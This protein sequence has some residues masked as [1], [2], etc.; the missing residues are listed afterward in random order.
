MTV[1]DGIERHMFVCF[2]FVLCFEILQ[3]HSSHLTCIERFFVS[4]LYKH[5]VRMTGLYSKTT[6]ISVVPG[7]ESAQ[8][9]AMSLLEYAFLCVNLRLF[10]VFFY[11]I[12]F[13]V[14]LLYNP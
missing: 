4:N 6:F 5:H 13:G 8:I 14:Y 7:C 11:L 10:S 2:L 3:S 1:N 12:I 9:A